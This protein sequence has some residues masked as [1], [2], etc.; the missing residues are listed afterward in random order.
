MILGLKISSH[1]RGEDKC[2]QKTAGVIHN[3]AVY[4]RQQFRSDVTMEIWNEKVT[5]MLECL[6]NTIWF[7]VLFF[8]MQCFFREE[9]VLHDA[10]LCE[11]KK[12]HCPFDM[13]S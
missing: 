1:T 12:A 6:S 11:K 10:V 4:N 9:P 7:V 3:C 13:S 5:R 8:Q 2:G